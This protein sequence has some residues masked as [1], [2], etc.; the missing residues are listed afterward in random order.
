M[1]KKSREEY[2]KYMNEY[3]TRRYHNRRAQFVEQ[4]GGKCA[5]CGS[6]DE[7][8]F[9][10]IDPSTKEFCISKLINKSRER[11]DLELA[12]CQLLCK[13]CHVK[14]TTE[15]GHVRGE[16]NGQSK[17]TEDSVREARRRYIKGCR[18]NGYGALAKEF[19]VSRMV[20]TSAIQGK[21]WKHVGR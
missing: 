2:N 7:L 5:R 21:T 11:C 12:K 20:M 16:K 14:K 6:T 18:K 1:P 4:L 17:L 13:K 8:H 19:G 10:H 15:E 3:M 9:D